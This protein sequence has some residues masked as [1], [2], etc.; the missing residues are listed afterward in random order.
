MGGPGERNRKKRQPQCL[1]GNRTTT[2]AGQAAFGVR[3]LL[4]KTFRVG[5]I[6]VKIPGAGYG[7]ED[8]VQWGYSNLDTGLRPRALRSCG[9]GRCGRDTGHLQGNTSSFH[10]FLNMP[11]S[12]LRVREAEIFPINISY[13]PC[14]RKRKGPSKGTLSCC[15]ASPTELFQIGSARAMDGR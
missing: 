2:C 6:G 1:R 10:P 12:R 13:T 3:S 11:G 4:L 14:R 15:N 7:T 8:P 5:A 9:S